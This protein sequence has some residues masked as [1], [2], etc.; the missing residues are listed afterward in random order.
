MTVT[1]IC[2]VRHG[3]TDWN[4]GRR[5]QGQIDIPLNA[6]GR[7]QAQ[8]AAAGLRKQRFDVLYSSDLARTRET[9]AP[10]AA[11]LGLPVFAASGLRERHY[12]LMQGQTAEETRQRQPEIHARYAARD[13]DADL[14]GGESL[15]AFAA[16]VE[17]TLATLAAAHAGRRL[18]LVS[19]GGVLDIVYR[20]ATGRDLS[21][22]RDFS[23]PNAGIN[24]VELAA[25]QWR[26]L[27]WG[28][29]SHL[30]GAMDEV[31]G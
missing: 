11:A 29:C 27:A 24:W 13:P 3:E 18:L 12:G 17:A 1:R 7:A 4:A 22:P 9:A 23:I 2:M 20:L 10:I 14:G 6:V 28:D 26:L 19:H 30:A 21:S 31:A 25:G 8:A 5:L 15:R 16:R